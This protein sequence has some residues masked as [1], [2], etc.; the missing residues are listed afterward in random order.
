[1]TTKQFS[2]SSRSRRPTATLVALALALTVAV[3]AVLACSDSTGSH[4]KT[5]SLTGTSAG[6]SSID[7]GP[8]GPS[9]GDSSSFSDDLFR[10]GK[11]VGRQTVECR[12]TRLDGQ[13]RQL[14]EECTATA[15]L[16]EGRIEAH[17]VVP[18]AQVE[19]TPFTQAVTG[20]SG[21]YRR[22]RGELVIDESGPEPARLTFRL[23]R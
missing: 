3:P 10:H 15:A 1:M 2:T 17:G 14:N 8:R 23:R 20:G 4:G 6:E 9:V 13:A 7:V 12:I 5:I 21:A 16:P 22:S 11:A 18:A 19:S